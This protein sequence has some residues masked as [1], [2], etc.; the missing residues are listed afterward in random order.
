MKFISVLMFGFFC[1][2]GGVAK[3]SG[4]KEVAL[5]CA[6]AGVMVLLGWSAK[7]TAMDSRELMEK[8]QERTIERHTRNCDVHLAKDLIGAVT[9]YCA[10]NPGLPAMVDWNAIQYM[11]FCKWLFR[12]EGK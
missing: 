9:L 5:Y 4:H 1:F 2:A 6:L 3:E 8:S 12:K 10:K 7:A 11:E